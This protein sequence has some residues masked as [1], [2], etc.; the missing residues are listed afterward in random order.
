M[1][2]SIDA[3]KLSPKLTSSINIY[4]M[5]KQ[6]FPS[7]VN[8]R[9]GIVYAQILARAQSVY[10]IRLDVEQLPPE[11]RVVDR[12]LGDL[13]NFWVDYVC[14]HRNPG[15]LI[16]EVLK[17]QQGTQPTYFE[18]VLCEAF[19]K[20]PKEYL[21]YPQVTRNKHKFDVLIQ[22]HKAYFVA[23]LFVGEV[24]LVVRLSATSHVL[25]KNVVEEL[26]KLRDVDYL[27]YVDQDVY[28]RLPLDIFKP[29]LSFGFDA[30]GSYRYLEMKPGLL[31]LLLTSLESVGL[32]SNYT[33]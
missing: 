21:E 16:I 25:N 31:P 7:L 5:W 27:H 22:M 24:H 8:A 17:D 12:D 9:L 30:R 14:N 10:T 6:Q 33:I 29:F 13:Q 18:G 3:S 11:L 28:V 4:E 23:K 2:I 19:A 26:L 15:L 1:T 20:P 32:K